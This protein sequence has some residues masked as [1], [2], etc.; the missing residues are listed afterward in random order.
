MDSLTILTWLMMFSVY[1]KQI[2]ESYQKF[3]YD[4]F[5]FNTSY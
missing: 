5:R 1:I 4:S 2:N 3:N